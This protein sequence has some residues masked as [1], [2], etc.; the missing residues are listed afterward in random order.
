MFL[1][2]VMV[3]WLPGPGG[4]IDPENSDLSNLTIKYT[5][6]G[7][8]SFDT[9]GNLADSMGTLLNQPETP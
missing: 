6:I 1:L 9:A 7:N 2:M 3:T 8:L 4:A 5:R